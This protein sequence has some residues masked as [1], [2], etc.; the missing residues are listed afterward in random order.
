MNIF[1]EMGWDWEAIVDHRDTER[2]VRFV[3]NVVS[4]EGFL[5]DLC[6]GTGR[7][8][9]ILSENGINVIGMDLSRNLLRIA[10][11]RMKEGGVVFPLVRGEMRQFPFRDNVFAS[12]IS[13]FTSF[14]YLPS[15]VEDIKSFGEINRTLRDSGVFL[16][17]VANFEHIKRNFRARDWAEFE[18]YY[19]LEE[20]SLNL[21]NPRLIS[22]WTL[23][24]K[25]ACQSKSIRHEVRLYALGRLRRMLKR[26]R[27]VVRKL[28]GGY[29]KQKFSPKAS[30]MIVMAQKPKT[31]S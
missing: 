1:D 26:S 29:D 28:Y 10:K 2:E 31:T 24:R 12:V 14:G 13:I 8:S 7:H 11:Q 9:I 5:L 19:M 25:R 30:R 15:E 18:P 3:E 4:K 23:I 22:N 16:L 20:R 6:C 17:D 21:K 27:L